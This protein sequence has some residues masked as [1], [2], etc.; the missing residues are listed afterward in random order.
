MPAGETTL[1]TTPLLEI[2]LG[3]AAP[4]EAKSSDL[5]QNW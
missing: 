1:M 4:A 2:S 5:A 3:I